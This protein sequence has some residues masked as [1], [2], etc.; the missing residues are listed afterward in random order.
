MSRKIK[1]HDIIKLITKEDKQDKIGRKDMGWHLVL[2][3]KPDDIALFSVSSM[4][5]LHYTPKAFLKR[6]EVSFYG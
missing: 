4:N 6:Y 1:K 3:V 5:F 2:S